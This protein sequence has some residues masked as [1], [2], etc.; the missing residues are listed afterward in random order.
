MLLLQKLG[1]AIG[2]LLAIATSQLPEF[3]QQYRQ[4]LGGAID[5]INRILAEFDQ[6][7]FNA[8]LTRAEAIER[9]RANAD[10]LISQRGVRIQQSQERVA[11]LERQLKA[12]ESAGSLARLAVFAQDYDHGVASGA[13]KNF[14]P[15]APLTAEGLM[16]ALAGFIAGWTAWRLA[17]W[18]LSRRSRFKQ[19]SATA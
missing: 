12:F 13:W 3:A 19:G 16:A 11:R 10:P 7:A 2:F 8:K 5:E 4:R 14:E 9:L 15:A 1:W 17:L 6:D 18:P